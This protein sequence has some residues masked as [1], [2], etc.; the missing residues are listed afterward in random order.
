MKFSNPFKNILFSILTVSLLFTFLYIPNYI[1]PNYNYLYL[2]EV[3]TDCGN[4]FTFVVEDLKIKPVLR[5]IDGSTKEISVDQYLQDIAKSGF[6]FTCNTNTQA[7]IFLHNAKENKSTTISYLSAQKLKLDASTNSPDGFTLEGF[8]QNQK[9][10]Y[11]KKYQFIKISQN[12]VAHKGE[13]INTLCF[14]GYSNEIKF[15]GWQI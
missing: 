4:S 6:G 10:Y 9:E 3:F 1:K 7:E 13:C 14:S 15:L 8:G 11:L 12:L 2:N 5:N